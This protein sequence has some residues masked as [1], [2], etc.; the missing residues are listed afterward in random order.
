M[1][2]ECCKFPD[3]FTIS[4]TSRLIQQFA[5]VQLICEIVGFLFLIVRIKSIDY[6]RLLL[7]YI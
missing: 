3:H 7:P 6:E 2:L 4:T 1:E 5:F